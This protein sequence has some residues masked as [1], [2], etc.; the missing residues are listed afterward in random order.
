[1]IEGKKMQIIPGSGIGFGITDAGRYL[2]RITEELSNQKEP[3]KIKQCIEAG[4]KFELQA[5]K[6]CKYPENPQNSIDYDDILIADD[7]VTQLDKVLKDSKGLTDKEKTD[8]ATARKK[9]VD[10]TDRYHYGFE[11]RKEISDI[12]LFD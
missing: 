6:A 11:T 10:T 5:K 4:D 8:L 3:E 9:V 12:L 2:K 1:L 7:F